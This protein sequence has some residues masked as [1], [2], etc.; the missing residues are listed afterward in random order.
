MSVRRDGP[1][2]RRLLSGQGHTS[3]AHLFVGDS[4]AVWPNLVGGVL[5]AGVIAAWVPPAF[6]RVFLLTDHPTLAQVSGPL[7]I[8]PI[9]NRYRKYHGWRVTLY[10]AAALSPG[11]PVRPHQWRFGRRQWRART[12]P[13]AIITAT[14]DRATGDVLSLGK[15]SLCSRNSFSFLM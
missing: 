6:W 5:A 1:V 14:T 3:M 9:L 13:E 7:I 8:L 12:R 2:L 4:T 15:G 10:L 11:H